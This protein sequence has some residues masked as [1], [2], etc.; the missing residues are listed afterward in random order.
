MGKI[1]IKN[2]SSADGYLLVSTLFFMLF[3]AFFSHSMIQIT[4]NHIS[5][6]NQ[7]TDAYL[8][9][10]A[11]KMSENIIVEESEAN[12]FP[13]N[14]WVKT[15]VGSIEIKRRTQKEMYHYSLLLITENGTP[16]SSEFSIDF[17]DEDDIEEDSNKDNETDV[18]NE[19]IIDNSNEKDSDD[20]QNDNDEV[21]E[22]DIGN[23][24]NMNNNDDDVTDLNE[25]L[26]D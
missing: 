13:E 6:M 1:G 16:Y 11:L 3:S 25:D 9:K 7:L 5:Q 20:D 26:D 2:L 19:T 22:T 8:A 23:N 14:G 18:D 24:E 15:S 10:S 17:M 12:N 21:D 4:A